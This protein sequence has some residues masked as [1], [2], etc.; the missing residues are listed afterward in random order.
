MIKI[1]FG[2]KTLDF[3]D[4]AHDV[5]VFMPKQIQP[6]I[7]QTHAVRESFNNHVVEKKIDFLA[8]KSIAIGINDQTR[9]IPNEI[10]IPELLNLL[11][12]N[13]ADQE[14]ITFYIATGTHT[15]V[16]SEQFYQ[17]LSPDVI[18]RYQI[19]SHDCDE[20]ENLFYIGTT[21]RNTSVFINKRFF[22]SDIKVVI[23]SIEP[24]HFMGFS[25]GYK[26][27]SIGLASR[28]TISANHNLLK[29]PGTTMGLFSSN[30]MRQEVEEIGR[31]IGVDFALNVVLNDHKKVLAS[32]WGDPGKV[33]MEGIQYF[34]QH[35]QLDFIE[36]ANQF[37]LVIAS[38]GG[39]PKDINFY[40]SQ[41]AISHACLFTKPGGKIILAAE[42]SDGPG[43]DKF[44]QYITQRSSFE[45]IISDFENRPFEIGPHKAY[46]LALQGLEHEIILISDIEPNIVSRFLVTPAESLESSISYVL[47]KLP[48]NPK[49]ALL[50][51]ATH[52]MPRMID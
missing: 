38:P 49:I 32:F 47:K 39:Y 25:G 19:E 15:P 50:P 33:I 37:D 7:N 45:E 21:T 28:E 23:G 48:E 46:Q 22:Q 44:M 12:K 30:P 52:T 1:P 35:M 29:Q 4:G 40:Q 31:M 10:L 36:P 26:T 8:K 2:K 3:C 42:C 11:I 41:K 24:H 20:S 34:R 14:R 51:Y 18:S 43:S 9:P 16:R 5:T 13:R 27:A 17:I 6:P